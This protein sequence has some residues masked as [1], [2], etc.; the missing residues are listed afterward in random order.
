MPSPETK[1]LFFGLEVISPWPDSLPQ[2]RLLEESH[3]HLTLAFLGNTDFSKLSVVLPS[4]PL[5]SFTMG[6]VGKFD[7]CLFLPE[8]HPHVVAWHVEW[9]DNADALGSYQKTL[10]HWLMSQDFLPKSESQFLPH[11]TLCRKP[12]IKKNWEKS[13]ETLPLIAKDIHLYESLGG[14]KYRPIWTQSFIAPFDEID[15]TADI[16]FW[17]RGKNLDQLY[18]HAQTALAFHSPILMNYFLNQ[19]SIDTLDSIIARL[20]GAITRADSEI[21]CSLKAVSYHGHILEK[22]NILEWEMIVDV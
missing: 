13:F 9:M 7:K 22:N 20:N 8:K 2:G 14:L 15:H 12:F 21:G 17:I 11:V 16:A 18:I 3:R 6:L 10:T 4:I 19:G 1:R 5:P